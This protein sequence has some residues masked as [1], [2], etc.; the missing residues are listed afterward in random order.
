MTTLKDQVREFVKFDERLSEE[1]YWDLYDC[2]GGY[3]AQEGMKKESARLSPLL[4][5]LPEM[6]EALEAIS[7]NGEN[8]NMGWTPAQH[9]RQTLAKI[10]E[11]V[12]ES[13]DH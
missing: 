4:E 8:R 7:T 9:A 3:S 12:G 10:K 11:A 2:S 1:I 6:V 13:D 5:L